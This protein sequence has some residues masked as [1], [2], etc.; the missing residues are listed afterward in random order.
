MVEKQVEYK[1][2]K[3]YVQGKIKRF[4]LVLITV[5]IGALIHT[6]SWKLGIVGSPKY[7]LTVARLIPFVDPQFSVSA[8]FFIASSFAD[9]SLGASY[10]LLTASTVKNSSLNGALIAGTAS[11]LSGIILILFALVSIFFDNSAINLPTTLAVWATIG[12]A[13]FA[14]AMNLIAA[15]GCSSIFGAVGSFLATKW[16]GHLNDSHKT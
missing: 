5:F 9:S 3:P 7:F 6:I 4:V 11:M 2:S 13:L 1:T 8:F 12:F 14:F 16:A 15:I 10:A